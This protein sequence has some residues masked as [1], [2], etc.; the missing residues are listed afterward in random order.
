MIK[1]ERAIKNLVIANR[2]LAH[3][4]VLDAYGHVSVRHPLDP[5]R[6]L[7]SRSCSPG[8]VEP[9]DIIEFR[10]DGVPT[11]HDSRPLYLERHIHG[12]I[13]ERHPDVLAV[14]HAHSDDILPFTITDTPL[15]P[16]IQAVGDMGENIPIWDIAN[17][18]GDST[19][20]LITSMEQGRDL[21]RSFQ[22]NHVTLLR[23][24]GFVAIGSTLFALVRLSVFLPR[25]ARVLL[26]ALRL[27]PVKGLSRGEVQARKALDVNSDSMRRGWEYWAREAACSHLLS[28]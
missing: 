6:Y 2:I 12:A 17:R 9:E 27:G 20:L 14:V 15:R 7:L 23:G 10:L 8:I 21:A 28:D 16:A 26:A 11:Q 4:Q 19:D 1:V 24:H 25:N 3:Q 18:F 13:Y 22:D 5:E